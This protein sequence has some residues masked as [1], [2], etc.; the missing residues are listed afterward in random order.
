MNMRDY[1]KR[2]EKYM[3]EGVS[4]D[5]IKLKKINDDAK[6]L[7]NFLDKSSSPN[8]DQAEKKIK[9]LA[10]TALKLDNVLFGEDKKKMQDLATGKFPSGVGN[11]V[12]NAALSLAKITR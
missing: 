6:K 1:L 12:M 4:P 3:N 2:A 11:P 10:K 9:K 5:Q 7:S 8:F